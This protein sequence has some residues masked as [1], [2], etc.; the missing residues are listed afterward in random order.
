MKKITELY[1]H[2][3]YLDENGYSLFRD[4]MTENTVVEVDG[5][6][7]EILMW[8]L[9]FQSISNFFQFIELIR[10]FFEED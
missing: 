7:K 3:L 6:L 10:S 9:E 5:T 8:Y 1:N 4:N 2:S